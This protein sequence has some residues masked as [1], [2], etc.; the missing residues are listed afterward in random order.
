MQIEKVEI[1]DERKS[2]SGNQGFNR[3][4]V[5]TGNR[6]IDVVSSSCSLMNSIIATCI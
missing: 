4:L 3:N 1:E 5:S 6:E 2:I